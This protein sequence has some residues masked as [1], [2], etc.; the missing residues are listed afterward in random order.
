MNDNPAGE[1]CPMIH[2]KPPN[3]TATWSA[4]LR[5]RLWAASRAGPGR[6]MLASCGGPTHDWRS[7]AGKRGIP[8]EIAAGRARGDWGERRP[9]PR[10]PRP[11]ARNPISGAA[12]G[13]WSVPNVVTLSL[14]KIRLELV[15]ARISRRFSGS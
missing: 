4:S 14:P 10:D 6:Q 7:G 2:R 13:T 11:G 9:T 8:A 3:D 1:V 12:P 5:S 15:V